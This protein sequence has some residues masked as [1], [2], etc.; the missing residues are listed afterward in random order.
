MFSPVCGVSDLFLVDT[1]GFEF[2]GI[3]CMYVP[4]CE[5]PNLF[6]GVHHRMGVS[7]CLC[8][9]IKGVRPDLIVHLCPRM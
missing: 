4:G 5:V 9:F 8:V 7:D 2:S 6:V 3:L 1:A